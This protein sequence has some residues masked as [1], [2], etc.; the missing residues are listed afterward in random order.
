MAR[1]PKGRSFK[2]NR[3]AMVAA[4]PM[5]K[6]GNEPYAE[7]EEP[8]GYNV[9]LVVANDLEKD[10]SRV[11]TDPAL[12]YKQFKAKDGTSKTGML[13]LY[14]K[15]QYNAMM[16]VANTEGTHPVFN[17]DLMAKKDGLIVNTKSLKGTDVPFDNEVHKARTAEVRAERKVA[18]E[19]AAA[20]ETEKESE[21][22]IED[23]EL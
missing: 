23:P 12:I 16:T 18:R 11:I 20:K 14:S 8:N 9:Q 21:A 13:A 22:S 19:A 5:A 4:F 2:D 1:F 3:I 15:D 7:G 10:N 17:A 6:K